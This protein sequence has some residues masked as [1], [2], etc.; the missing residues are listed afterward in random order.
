MKD[1]YF[2]DKSSAAASELTAHAS[3]IWLQVEMVFQYMLRHESSCWYQSSSAQFTSVFPSAVSLLFHLHIC[4]ELSGNWLSTG[5]TW[6]RLRTFQWPVPTHLLS[7][8]GYQ[9]LAVAWILK[10]LGK[11]THFWSIVFVLLWTKPAQ[12]VN[13]MDLHPRL[14]YSSKCL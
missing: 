12:F 11:E 6:Q 13:F 3:W 8:S 4:E 5:K 7:L 2:S 14:V 10:Y 1:G 9:S